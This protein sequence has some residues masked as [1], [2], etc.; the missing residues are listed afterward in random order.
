MSK[1]RTDM[2]IEQEILL[3]VQRINTK[4]SKMKKALITTASAIACFVLV[5]VVAVQSGIFSNGNYIPP[6]ENSETQ[7]IP[8]VK[9]KA[10]PLDPDVDSLIVDDDG[11]PYVIF[12]INI[13]E[14]YRYYQIDPKDYEKYGIGSKLEKSDF[15]DLIGEIAEYKEDSQNNFITSNEESIIGA[16][17]YS[18]TPIPGKGLVIVKGKDCCNLFLLHEYEPE[19]GLDA[20]RFS[21]L[22]SLF[23]IDSADEIESLEYSI[24]EL[25]S[26]GEN[27]GFNYVIMEEG[28]VT[29]KAKI[30][31]FYEMSSLFEK[32]TGN[33]PFL[34]NLL[35]DGYVGINIQIHLKNGI[36]IGTD[37]SVMMGIN[38]YYKTDASG[39]LDYC[40]L[41][42]PEQSLELRNIFVV[43]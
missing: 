17:V 21:D 5:A 32:P 26:L 28:Q 3:R 41:L 34:D 7:G 22:Y 19:G 31:K 25:V 33:E 13:G 12:N 40:E 24:G 23:E 10:S 18:Y 2:E 35:N 39:Y 9:F 38:F 4:K 37:D 8:L 6:N 29:D 16:S 11:L 1:N 15:G 30:A 14:F 36:I 42:T 43:D 20:L 27:L